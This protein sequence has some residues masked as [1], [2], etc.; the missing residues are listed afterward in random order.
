MQVSG[1]W[2]VI[3]EDESKMY[4]IESPVR[5]SDLR[6]VPSKPAETN[7][8]HTVISGDTL[9]EIAKHY[10]GDGSRFPE[11]KKLNKLSSNIIYVG[12]KLK[13]PD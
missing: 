3:N 9:W 11:I 12:W 8:I 5:A 1:D 7:R 10:L 6:L 13:I 4:R 2:A